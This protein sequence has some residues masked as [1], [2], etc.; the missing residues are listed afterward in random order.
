MAALAAVNAAFI[1][2]G[3]GADAAANLADPNK[4]NLTLVSLTLFEAKDVK[5]L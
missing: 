5:T 1:R 4:E 3:F 2:M